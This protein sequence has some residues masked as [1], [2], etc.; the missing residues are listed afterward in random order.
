[1]MKITPKN[2]EFIINF[3]KKMQLHFANG[4]NDQKILTSMALELPTIMKIIEST[5]REKLDKLCQEYDGFYYY[6][7]L[8]EK[9]AMGISNGTITFPK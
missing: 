5:Q 8:L 9:L 1:M 2:L 6:M 4:Y 7:M 3:D